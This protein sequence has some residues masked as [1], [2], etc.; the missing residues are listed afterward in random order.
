MVVQAPEVEKI[1]TSEDVKGYYHHAGSLP[2]ITREVI[3]TKRNIKSQSIR[4][5]EIGS[6]VNSM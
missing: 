4:A 3:L 5:V 1:D 6:C 2:S